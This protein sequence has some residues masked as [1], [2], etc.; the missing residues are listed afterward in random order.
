[1]SLDVYL[2]LPEPLDGP[3]RQAIFIRRAGATEEISR[4]EWDEMRPGVE[5][6]IA[7]INP[8]EDQVYWANITHNLGPMAREAGIYTHLWRPEQI[9]VTLAADLVEPLT[10][11]LALLRSDPARFKALNS[12]NG[13]GRYEHFVP[14]VERYLEACRQYP[15]A[16]VSACR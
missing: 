6:V 5:P 8:G 2:K 7:T 12:H 16:K 1:M 9:G 15:A 3:P 4:A 10:A 13:W 11:G 14:F